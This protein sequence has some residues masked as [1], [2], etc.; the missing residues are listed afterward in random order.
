MF[1]T[2]SGHWACLSRLYTDYLEIISGLILPLVTATSCYKKITQFQSIVITT[3][4]PLCGSAHVEITGKHRTP[5]NF[6]TANEHR[7]L[8]GSFPYWYD[9]DESSIIILNLSMINNFFLIPCKGTLKVLFFFRV[10]VRPS[11]NFGKK[12]E[13]A[14]SH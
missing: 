2:Y 12:G 14:N 6:F 3:Y 5:S 9:L 13:K 1:F 10:S 4:G 7:L 8:Y 11:H